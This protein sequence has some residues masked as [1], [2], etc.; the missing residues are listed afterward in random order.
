MSE[1][2]DMFNSLKAH[3]SRLRAKYGVPCPEC[4]KKLPKACPTILL[5]Q[6]RCKIH[7]YVDERPELTAEEYLHV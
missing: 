7:K 3:K 5:P 6:H 2:T 1:C 4:I